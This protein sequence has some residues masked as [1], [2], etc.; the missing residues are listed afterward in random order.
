MCIMGVRTSHCHNDGFCF[1]SYCVLE[2]RGGVILKRKN[3]TCSS[4]NIPGVTNAGP[5]QIRQHHLS[6]PAHRLFT[7][8]QK[9]VLESFNKTPFS[10][11]KVTATS[12]FLY[13]LQSCSLLTNLNFITGGSS[14][15]NCQEKK[16]LSV[17]GF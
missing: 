6:L 14:E 7:R 11:D 9:I 12:F 5:C 17:L 4:T 16:K 1:S 8:G 10:T 2:N 13:D 15:K 3:N